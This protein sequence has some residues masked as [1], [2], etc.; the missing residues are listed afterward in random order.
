MRVRMCSLELRLCEGIV[1][2]SLATRSDIWNLVCRRGLAG[3]A[4]TV[5]N[6]YSGLRP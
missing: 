6:Q 1:Q 2:P 4:E 5:S 3:L